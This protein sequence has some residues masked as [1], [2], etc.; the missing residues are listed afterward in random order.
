MLLMRKWHIKEKKFIRMHLRK[1]FKANPSEPTPDL[2]DE[3][4]V[5]YFRQQRCSYQFEKLGVERQQP[6]EQEPEDG[7]GAE[8]EP[9]LGQPE[10]RLVVALVEVQGR[11]VLGPWAWGDYSV[12]NINLLRMYKRRLSTT[13]SK[14]NTQV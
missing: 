13:Y 11:D 5:F 12:L 3:P 4:V 2:E 10:A 9:G 6:A 14:R 8:R 7:R 1:G